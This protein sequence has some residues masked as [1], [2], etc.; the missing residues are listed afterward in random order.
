M[1]T[2][3]KTIAISRPPAFMATTIL[4]VNHDYVP[5]NSGEFG[6]FVCDI[7]HSIFDFVRDIFVY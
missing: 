3:E 4:K 6:S 5:N 7:F 1:I 2:A